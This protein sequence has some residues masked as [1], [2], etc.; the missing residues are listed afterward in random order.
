[1]K[2]LVKDTNTVDKS[3]NRE[4]SKLIEEKAAEDKQPESRNIKDKPPFDEDFF[5]VCSGE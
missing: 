4:F 5:G 3:K 1:M 2:Y